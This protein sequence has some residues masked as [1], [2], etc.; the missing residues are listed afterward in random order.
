MPYWTCPSSA[1]IDV[2]LSGGNVMVRGTA[3]MAQTSPLPVQ[4]ATAGLASFSAMMATARVRTSCAT[5]TRTAMMAQMKTLCYVVGPKCS[6]FVEAHFKC[7]YFLQIFTCL[8]HNIVENLNPVNWFGLS[9]LQ[10]HT[11]VKRT[12]G[13]AQISGVSLSHG[14]ATVRMTVVI[15]LMK[16]RPTA[17]QGLAARDSSSA[18]MDVASPRT[19]NV[20]LMMIVVTTLMN[21]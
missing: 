3:E 6:A 15:S 9:S 12:S 1:S 14:S 8:F 21:R 19:G 13:N 17:P 20:M 16:T 7:F 5:A 10:I 18:A 11:S 4:L 2:F